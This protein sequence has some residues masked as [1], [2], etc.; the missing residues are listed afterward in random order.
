MLQKTTI[1][2]FV[3]LIGETWDGRGASWVYF[4]M[5]YTYQF[6]WV[7]IE[8]SLLLRDDDMDIDTVITTDLPATGIL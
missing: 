5:N 6:W 8:N 4:Q 3:D 2:R 1:E 7:L